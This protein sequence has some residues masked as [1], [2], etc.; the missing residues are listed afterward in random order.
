MICALATWKRTIHNISPAWVTQRTRLAQPEADK[1][2]DDIYARLSNAKAGTE[3]AAKIA[4]DKARKAA[5]YSALWMFVALLLGAFFANLLA[6]FGGKQRD[7]V[8]VS[9]R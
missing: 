3:A 6:T 2:V 4:A 1:R 5:A 8:N 7:G 9:P